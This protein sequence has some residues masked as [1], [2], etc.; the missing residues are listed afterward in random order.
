MRKYFIES[1]RYNFWA[2]QRVLTCID[3]ENVRDKKVLTLFSHIISA[4][5]IWNLRIKGLP[6]TPFPLWETYKIEELKTMTEDSFTAWVELIKNNR[7][8]TF[9]EII[10]Y[11]NSS[12]KKFEN[13]ISQIISQ[14]I[15]HSAH[16]RGQINLKIRELGIEPAKVDYI[17]F[18]R[19]S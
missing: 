11:K 12:G 7:S 16:H 2:N 8:T 19:L 3:K 10:F 1:F 14:V 6:V 17:H 13:T 18:K 5:M 4:E 9:Q 15:T